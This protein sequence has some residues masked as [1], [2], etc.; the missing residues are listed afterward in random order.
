MKFSFNLN[1][2][3]VIGLLAAVLL[4]LVNTIAFSHFIRWDFTE[5]KQYVISEVSKKTVDNLDD[6]V[7]VKVYF[8]QK[9]PPN[10]VPLSQ[11]V[12]DIL[13]EY[14]AYSN[15]NLQVEF[16]DPSKEEI[17]E[18][19]KSLGIPEV[20]MNVLEKDKW[21]VQNGF[22]GI[23]LLYL[24]KKEIIPVVRQTNGFEYDFTS[25]LKRL[26]ATEVKSVGFLTGNSAHGIDNPNTSEEPELNDYGVVARELSKTYNV[27]KVSAEFGAEIKDIDTLV[28]PG[29]KE[30]L[31]ERELFEIDQ[32]IIGGGRAIFLVD[33][34]QVLPDFTAEV[35]ETGLQEFLNHYG[36]SVKNN[37]VLDKINE[38][39]PFNS[40]L[41][42]FLLPYPFWPKFV[43]ANLNKENPIV[44][45]LETVTMTWVSS[46]FKS[47][48]SPQI[49]LEVEEL[50]TTSPDGWIQESPFNLDPNQEFN[51]EDS[52]RANQS[53]MVLATAAFKS[54]FEG[55]S[56]PLLE[57]ENEEG[58]LEKVENSDAGREIIPSMNENGQI[59]VIGDS[60]FITDNMLNSFPQNL[61][62]FLNAVDYLTLDS[63]L[64]LIR[65]KQVTERPL[66]ELTDSQRL[67]VKAIGVL[68]APA[69]FIV[70]GI[71]RALWRKKRKNEV[72]I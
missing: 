36:V 65:S 60:D 62:L 10:L 68:L 46:V 11:Y 20:Q 64:I 72:S 4:I 52:L 2:K 19:A 17:A 55:K 13:E 33:G 45:E 43:A 9:L 28:I 41:I 22:L 59:I 58:V 39:V 25:A 54:Y 49:N 32:F 21:Q 29:P 26:T 40:G 35:V 34:A 31:S 37:F 61:T 8:S 15:G 71:L 50:V 48:D 67:M 57:I 42:Q 56:V 66:E 14:Q 63:D 5:D 12:Q 24:D 16:L 23:G 44:S 69:L 1:N 18:E 7:A 47:G 30:Q 53:V 27:K 38:T 51:I 6:L 70:F 3:I